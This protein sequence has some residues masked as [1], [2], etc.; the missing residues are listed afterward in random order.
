LHAQ[1]PGQPFNTILK[2]VSAADQNVNVVLDTEETI[3]QIGEDGGIP[4]VWFKPM[5]PTC[6]F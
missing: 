2:Q 1:Q 5:T 3:I 4:V 6:L